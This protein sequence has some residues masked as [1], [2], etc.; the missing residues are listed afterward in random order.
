[1]KTVGGGSEGRLGLNNLLFYEFTFQK[2]FFTKFFS[3]LELHEVSQSNRFQSQIGFGN[4][5]A[6]IG[7]NCS[8]LHLCGQRS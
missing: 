4:N 7:N 6:V 8:K 3:R 1:M 5:P 2:Y